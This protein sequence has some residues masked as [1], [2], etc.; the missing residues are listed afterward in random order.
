MSCCRCGGAQ[1]GGWENRVAGSS[2][3]YSPIDA[4]GCADEGGASF[5]IDLAHPMALFRKRVTV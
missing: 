2:R 4:I 1:M 3:Q 5:A